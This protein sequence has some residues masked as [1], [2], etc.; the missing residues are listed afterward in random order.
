VPLCVSLI[1]L[2]RRPSIGLGLRASLASVFVGSDGGLIE[3]SGKSIDFSKTAGWHLRAR[4][5][6]KT[7]LRLSH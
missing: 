2:T 7:N 1:N 4:R 5:L 6:G 3:A